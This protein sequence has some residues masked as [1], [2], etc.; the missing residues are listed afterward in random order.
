MKKLICCLLLLPSFAM[1]VTVSSA[2][3]QSEYNALIQFIDFKIELIYC[4]RIVLAFILG[5]IIGITHNKQYKAVDFKVFTAVALGSGI[6]GSIS[7]HLFF[8]YN[9]PFAFTILAG[10]VTGV[11]FLGAAVIFKQNNTISGLSSAAILWATS[12]IGL[13]LG[14]GMYL[15]AFVCL[16]LIVLFNLC[17]KPEKVRILES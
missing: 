17:L 7:I 2:A 3:T 15:I 16:I 1:A 4:A 8:A 9:V 6:I 13:A 12:T 11:G 14:V 5:A 10:T